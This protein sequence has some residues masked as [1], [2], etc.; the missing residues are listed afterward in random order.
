MAIN[1]YRHLELYFD[2]GLGAVCSLNPRLFP[3]DIKYIVNHAEDKYIFVD[4]PFLPI[5]ENVISDLKT[6]KGIVIL[7]DKENI[8]SSSL[9][10]LICYEDFI[11]DESDTI[12]WPEF[13]ENTAS[14]T[15]LYLWV[16]Q[17]ISQG[18]LYSHRSTVLH[19]WYATAGN[20]MNLTP[21]T[22]LLPVVPMFHVNAWGIPYASFMYGARNGISGIATDGESIY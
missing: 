8:P 14:V 10:N 3:D 11:S 16:Q 13:D 1:S 15:L 4:A 12:S 19:A 20:A 18:V 21:E 7:T 17:E 22:I 5:I 6:V 2:I 9:E